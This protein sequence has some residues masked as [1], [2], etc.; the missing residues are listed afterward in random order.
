MDGENNYESREERDIRLAERLFDIL[1][2]D[3]RIVV[4]GNG[5]L[6]LTGAEAEFLLN[7]MGWMA[8]LYEGK[9]DEFAKAFEQWE[10]EK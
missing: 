8:D 4:C 1:I 5:Y 3:A 2:E 10:D 9:L 6:I 7:N